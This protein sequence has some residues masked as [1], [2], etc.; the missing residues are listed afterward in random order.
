MEFVVS[1][2]IHALYEELIL[3]DEIAG[4]LDPDSNSRIDRRRKELVAQ[5]QQLEKTVDR[6]FI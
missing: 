3:L 6:S 1:D 5:I 4:E 2:Q